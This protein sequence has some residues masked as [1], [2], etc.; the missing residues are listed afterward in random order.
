MTKEILD[1]VFG[2]VL[3]KTL[4]SF[5]QARLRRATLLRGKAAHGINVLLPGGQ[6][7]EPQKDS[8]DDVGDADNDNDCGDDGS[9]EML[10]GTETSPGKLQ[11]SEYESDRS[12]CRCRLGV[13]RFA[14]RMFSLSVSGGCCG[15]MWY[16]RGVASQKA[17]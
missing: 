13:S 15:T 16:A 1:D 17:R 9:M 3:L 7:T 6:G 10:C 5:H 4:E 11:A 8:V 2:E 12:E 14:A